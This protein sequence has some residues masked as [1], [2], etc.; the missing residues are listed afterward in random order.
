MTTIINPLNHD[1]YEQQRSSSPLSH[2]QYST[3]G[4]RGGNATYPKRDNRIS[5]SPIRRTLRSTKIRADRRVLNDD[6]WRWVAPAF[7]QAYR[8]L[9]PDS[10]C[11]SFYGWQH[12]E[13]F[14]TVWKL[15]GFYPVA[16]LVWPKRYPSSGGVVG[17]MHEQAYVL[18][19]GYP[20]RPGFRL[21]DVL[22]WEYS[23]NTRHPTEKA[24]SV[25]KPLIRA[26]SKPGAITRG[27]TRDQ[28]PLYRH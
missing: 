17:Y 11:V 4:L 20:P 24:V 1:S 26:F 6:N 10:Y 23:G 21:P 2:R 14:L 7:S 28:S 15:L 27:G 8:V 18:A 5:S 22:P 16:H 9:K 13:K 3:R 19:K 12:I 25:M